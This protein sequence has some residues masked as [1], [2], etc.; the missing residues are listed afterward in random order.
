[1]VEDL[2]QARRSARR[3][4]S[5]SSRCRSGSRAGSGPAP[6][7]AARPC[8]P[9]SATAGPPSRRDRGSRPRSAAGRSRRGRTA[10]GRGSTRPRARPC[11]PRPSRSPARSRSVFSPS[12]RSPASTWQMPCCTCAS[13]RRATGRS[14]RAAMR[15]SSVAASGKRSRWYSASAWWKA[16]SSASPV[17][18]GSATSEK[19]WRA[20]S[21]L[22][23]RS[24][25]RPALNRARVRCGLSGNAVTSRS[26]QAAA[27]A[28]SS[29][30]KALEPAANSS[31]S[32][33]FSRAEVRPDLLGGHRQ[34][35]A[36]GAGGPVVA[37]RVSSR[38]GSRAR[39]RW[40][41][42]ARKGKDGE[43]EA[44]SLQDRSLAQ[45]VGPCPPEC[46]Q[47]VRSRPRS[48]EP[49]PAA[50]APCPRGG[51]GR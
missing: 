21:Q 6:R 1:M 29:A 30:A 41:A 7:A 44:A 43:T 17:P 15:P 33:I 50:P 42:A 46:A 2:V 38:S 12:S 51:D 23:I 8:T 5:P 36:P 20:A 25:A 27:R 19:C 4:R 9:G 48:G 18:S 26:K 39:A 11:R 35:L 31:S 45:Q 13:I 24:R 3:R 10:P 32:F 37:H 14:A 47:V 16:A 22:S 40:I 49:R 34:R 28:G